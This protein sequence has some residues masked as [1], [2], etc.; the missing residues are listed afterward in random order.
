MVFE[1]NILVGYVVATTCG[2]WDYV[3]FMDQTQDSH[4]QNM[5]SNLD[6]IPIRSVGLLCWTQDKYE[7]YRIKWFNKNISKF[8]KIWN[9]F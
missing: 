9:R 1:G 3:W 2:F 6:N 5:S 8:M 7:V 4:M